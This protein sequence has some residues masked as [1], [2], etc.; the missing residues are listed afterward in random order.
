[1]RFGSQRRSQL[2][3]EHAR[4]HDIESMSDGSP[5]VGCGR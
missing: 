1:L 2:K 3:A 4:E 5:F